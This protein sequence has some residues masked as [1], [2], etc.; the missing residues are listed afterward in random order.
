MGQQPRRQ[1][2]GIQWR[3]KHTRHPGRGA[4]ISVREL[5]TRPEVTHMKEVINVEPWAL[6]TKYMVL[7]KCTGTPRVY[8]EYIEVP[9]GV[10]ESFFEEVRCKVKFKFGGKLSG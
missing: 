5:V 4:G 9:P 7:R 6:N 10:R 1:V 2:L 3:A 8:G